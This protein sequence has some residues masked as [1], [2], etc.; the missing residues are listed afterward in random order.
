MKTKILF[1]FIIICTFLNFAAAQDP[2]NK[3]HR[4]DT[5]DFK[6]L[7]KQL[8]DLETLI[9]SSGVETE[10]QKTKVNAAIQ[11]LNLQIASISGEVTNINKELALNNRTIVENYISKLNNIEKLSEAYKELSEDLI[12]EISSDRRLAFI[13]EI[14]NPSSDKLG[15]K[16]TD[17]ISTAA[18]NVAKKTEMTAAQRTTFETKFKNV[19]TG[20]QT[21]T[22]NDIAKQLASLHPAASATLTAF[23]FLANYYNVIYTVDKKTVTVDEKPLLTT[24]QLNEYLTS[25]TDFILYY[26]DLANVNSNFNIQ[27]NQL[28][29]DF[30]IVDSLIKK[31]DIIIAENNAIIKTFKTTTFTN[32]DVIKVRSIYSKTVEEV[33]KINEQIITNYQNYNLIRIEFYTNYIKQIE[34]SKELLSNSLVAKPNTSLA[35]TNRDKLIK[36]CTEGKVSLKRYSSDIEKMQEIYDQ[37]W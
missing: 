18:L 34:K 4:C 16:F 14:N 22:S 35:T 15:F 29:K 37:V 8:Y 20:I 32:N 28:E 5:M 27:L 21:F 19:V 23:N 7:Y 9:K 36:I 1:A 24:E 13:A 10:A 30:I 2:E 33:K 12:Y 3:V 11:E 26:E 6:K 25:I 31:L 17:I